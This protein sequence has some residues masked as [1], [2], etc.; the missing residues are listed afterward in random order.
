MFY[1]FFPQVDSLFSHLP[2]LAYVGLGPGPELVP[3]LIAFVTFVG[4]AFIAMVQWPFFVL[5]GWLKSKRQS[6]RDS[7]SD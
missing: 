1:P 3:Y 7:Q 2:L 5:L 4:A 6:R